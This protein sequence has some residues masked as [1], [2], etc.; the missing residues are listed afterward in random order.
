M[1]NSGV[2]SRDDFAATAQNTSSKNQIASSGDAEVSC[3]KIPLVTK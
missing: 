3:I 1:E 2:W